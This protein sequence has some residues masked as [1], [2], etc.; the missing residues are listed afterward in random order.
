ME[1]SVDVKLNGFENNSFNIPDKVNNIGLLDR[2]RNHLIVSGVLF[3]S[4][5]ILVGFGSASSSARNPE[6][7]NISNY[8]E[9][10]KCPS[11]AEKIKFEAI[12]CRYCG[13]EFDSS[14]VEEEIKQQNMTKLTQALESKAPG[15]SYAC[16]DCDFV[17][18]KDKFEE[19]NLFCPNCGSPLKEA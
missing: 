15:N 11:C 10:K 7:D 6:I 14:L 18:D 5:I 12:K 9:D 16:C 8:E 13:H 4:G 17:V 2:R 3:V 1:T 19:S